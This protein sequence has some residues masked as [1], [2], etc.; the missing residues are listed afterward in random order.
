MIKSRILAVL[1]CLAL[2][3]LG[4]GQAQ[5][6]GSSVRHYPQLGK[7]VADVKLRIGPSPIL[8]QIDTIKRGELV[9]I[10]K[11]S[12]KWCRI[13]Q[14]DGGPDG[15]MTEEYMIFMGEIHG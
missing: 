6:T 14:Q 2:L 11:C 15:Y 9:V 8:K 4:S 10:H 13:T 7:P 3:E 1:A 12:R 5:A